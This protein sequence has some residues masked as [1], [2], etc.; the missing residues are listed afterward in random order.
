VVNIA[1]RIKNNVSEVRQ[2]M[3]EACA[4]AGRDVSSVQLIAV[5]KTHPADAVLQAAS[6]GIT[7]FG[8]N[9]I[10]EAAPKMAAVRTDTPLVW[11]M[12]GHVQSR[13]ARDVVEHFLNPTNVV[14]SL[15]SVKL[16]ERF[17]RFT[18][19]SNRESGS[20]NQLAVL[21]EVNVSGEESKSGFD[22]YGWKTDAGVRSA[23]W[24]DIEQIAAL[25]GL[26]IDGLMTIAPIAEHP[27][28]ARPTFADL[29][30]LREALAADFPVGGVLS[31]GMTD[32]FP[33]AIEE[34]ATL[35]RVGRAIFGARDYR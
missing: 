16:A 2:Q 26:R 28:D 30:E 8:E 27:D 20:D 23:L 11:H 9:R 4:R 25:P 24:S 34:G 31:M 1:D 22:G 15:D 19:E 29:R 18:V 33:V 7:H 5:S 32:D 17:S 10:E 35:I 6:C 13:K 3:A 21:L 14:H 12:I